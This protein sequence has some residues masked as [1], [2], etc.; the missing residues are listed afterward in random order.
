MLLRR[1]CA[2]VVIGH[3]A[4]RVHLAGVTVNLGGGRAAQAAGD[5]L[6]DLGQ[7]AAC[8][9]FRI[10][11]RARRFTASLDAVFQPEGIRVLASP[12]QAPGANAICKRMIGT[13]RRELSGRL[14]IV[15]EHHLRRVVTE[16]LRHYN[17]ARPHRP[18]PACPGPSRHPA[19]GINLAGHRI[20]QKHVFGGLIHE[21]QIT[22]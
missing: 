19:A 6:M 16:H 12:A 9:E 18:W 8:A 1:L 4:R 20:R 10:R 21:Y 7:R 15:D 22:A 2:L 13:L 17:A 5:F 14:L 11:D 3:G